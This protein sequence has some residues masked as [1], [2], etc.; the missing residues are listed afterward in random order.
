M[1]KAGILYSVFFIF[2]LFLPMYLCESGD[3]IEVKKPDKDTT[4][5]RSGYK[6]FKAKEKAGATQKSE[7][8]EAR[9]SKSEYKKNE[10]LVK[11]QKNISQVNID[12]VHKKI[13]AKVKKTF[14]KIG[15]QLVEIPK[16]MD[17]QEAITNYKKDASVKFAEPNY[18][19]EMNSTTPN[20]PM[21]NDL[22]GLH[23][24]GQTGGTASGCRY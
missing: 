9:T 5:L 15:V 21:F 17:V 4:L 10:V 20:D 2:S 18:R 22:W 8:P 19:V 13:G 24:T 1:K 11:F 14:W 23:N 16:D 3:A 6:F 12:N 7:S